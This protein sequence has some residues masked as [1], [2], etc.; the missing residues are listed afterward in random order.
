MAA[1]LH[2]LFIAPFCFSFFLFPGCHLCASVHF[3]VIFYLCFSI[4]SLQH[5]HCAFIPAVSLLLL[6]LNTSLHV[7]IFVFQL[8]DLV[9]FWV[10]FF[11]GVVFFRSFLPTSSAVFSPCL[12]L[13][14]FIFSAIMSVL[15][16]PPHLA[17]INARTRAE[18]HSMSH[19]QFTI[20]WTLNFP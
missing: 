2:P 10:G 12:S 14:L 20:K 7:L 19:H 3:H 18:T 17:S 15:L 8:C 13:Y 11:F 1:L 16:C 9:S 6:S 4:P 5:P